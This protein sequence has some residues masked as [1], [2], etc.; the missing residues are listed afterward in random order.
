MPVQVLLVG[1]SP[2]D[3]IL[4]KEAALEFFSDVIITVA[5]DAQTALALLFDPGFR[6]QLVVTDGQHITADVEGLLHR[7]DARHVP[8]VVFS[9]TLSP[10]QVTKIL[11]LGAREYVVKPVHSD[12]F[13]GAVMGILSKWVAPAQEA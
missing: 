9:S 10:E 13:R 4:I 1:H 5:K 7:S 11:G 12:E 3:V 2:S 8:V 6:P